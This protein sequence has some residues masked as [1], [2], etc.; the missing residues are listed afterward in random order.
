MLVQ[1]SKTN[2]QYIFI[3]PEVAVIFLYKKALYWEKVYFISSYQNLILNIKKN[4]YT[5]RAKVILVAHCIVK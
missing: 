3:V 1:S 5:E 4:I 2:P